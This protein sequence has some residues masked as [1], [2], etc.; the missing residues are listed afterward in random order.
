MQWSRKQL[1]YYIRKYMLELDTGNTLNMTFLHIYN[2][3]VL[4]REQKKVNKQIKAYFSKQSHHCINIVETT[5]S[6]NSRKRTYE[7]TTILNYSDKFKQRLDT[8]IV[9][10]WIL[11]QERELVS[12]N[13]KLTILSVR[14]DSEV[15]TSEN[16]YGPYLWFVFFGVLARGES[17]RGVASCF[18]SVKTKRQ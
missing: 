6:S 10:Q 4:K 5:E 16:F 13:A 18:T 12:G 17:V 1:K 8:S 7:N 15:C 14:L 2:Y 11:K 3:V 9:R